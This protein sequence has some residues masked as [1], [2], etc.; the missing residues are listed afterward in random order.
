MVTPEGGLSLYMF[1]DDFSKDTRKDYSII[2]KRNSRVTEWGFIPLQDRAGIYHSA[3]SRALILEA[4]KDDTVSMTRKIQPL[5][6]FLL[7]I[8]MTPL[9]VYPPNGTSYLVMFAG[10]K[11]AITAVIP[12]SSDASA[13]V[14]AGSEN[15]SVH[16]ALTKK[17]YSGIPDIKRH[18]H[19]TDDRY[20]IPSPTPFRIRF[21]REQN[22]YSLYLEEEKCIEFNHISLHD[23]TSVM[24]VSRNQEI[25]LNSLRITAL[26][27]LYFS[28]IRKTDPEVTRALLEILIENGN[29][30]DHS[31]KAAVRCSD[32]IAEFKNPSWPQKGD[33]YTEFPADIT[34]QYTESNYLI[35]TLRLK[36]NS[37]YFLRHKTWVR[38][39]V[40]AV[41]IRETME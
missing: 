24:I 8:S 41:L 16:K 33:P 35:Y 14:I 6:D 10:E 15:P 28:E 30:K 34:A 18:R 11:R 31:L 40:K 9:T 23:I 4:G 20:T 38:P 19:Q 21:I 27:G 2:L 32:R 26:D 29:I 25:M 17:G 7:D 39:C 22:V 13:S 37:V 36:M 5:G 1:S 3:E 12:G